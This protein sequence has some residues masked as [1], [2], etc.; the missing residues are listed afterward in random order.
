ME[1]INE[2]LLNEVTQQAQNNPRLRMNHNFHE[3]LDDQVQ[4]LLHALE[5]GTLIPIHRH[6]ETDE[7]Y[8]LLRGKI[9]VN[10]YDDSGERIKEIELNPNSGSYGVNI[11]AGEW[12]SLEVLESGSVIFEVKQGPYKP[13]EK[14]DIL[15]IS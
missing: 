11:K 6:T 8:I 5:P 13:V 1:A 14:K 10:C 3:S 7:M 12:H 15:G 4:R 9:R 2:H